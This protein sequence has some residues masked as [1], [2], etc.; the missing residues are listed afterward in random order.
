[1][2]EVIKLTESPRLNLQYYLWR[3]TLGYNLHP[4][5]RTADEEDLKIADVGT[6]TGHAT[7]RSS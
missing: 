1:M 5:I 3:E 7:T 6:G 2:H 4:S